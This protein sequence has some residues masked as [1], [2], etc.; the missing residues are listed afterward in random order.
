MTLHHRR[1]RC[2][3]LQSASSAAAAVAAQPAPAADTT[4]PGSTLGLLARWLA[5]LW[6]PCQPPAVGLQSY[7]IAYTAFCLLPATLAALILVFFYYS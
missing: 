2:R 5:L 6:T 1:R 7:L 3:R 4:L